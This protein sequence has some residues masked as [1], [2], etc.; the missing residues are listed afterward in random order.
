M[1]QE[2]AEAKAALDADELAAARRWALAGLRN[3]PDS[4][5]LLRVASQASLELDSED[6]PDILRRLV[7]LVPDDADAWADL[8]VALIDADRFDE[9]RDTLRELLRLRPHHV[10]TLV[11]LAHTSF[12]LGERAEAL[13]LLRSAAEHAPDDPAV[14]RTLVDVLTACGLDDE[15][16]V[17]A[18]RL[19]AAEPEDVLSLLDVAELHLARSDF[20]EAALAFERARRADLADGHAMYGYH[21]RIEAEV[22]AERWRPALDVA[23]E[24]TRADRSQLTTDLLSFV[25][26]RLF[27]ES[28]D[29]RPVRTWD[30]LHAELARGRAEHRRMHAE[31][32]AG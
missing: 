5:E 14:L 21:G 28:E 17:W 15:A 12:A 19:T 2:L 3:E 26:T 20:R 24:A 8:S 4:V 11:N 29:G 18:E 23:I 30:D 10:E 7:A 9:A 6:A 1:G 32:L 16:L 13:A 22:L 25:A 27:G 31:A